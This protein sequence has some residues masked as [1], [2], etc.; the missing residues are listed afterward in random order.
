MLAFVI[1]KDCSMAVP[2]SRGTA[3]ICCDCPRW[4]GRSPCRP[5]P[6]DCARGTINLNSP[7]EI[8]GEYGI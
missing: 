5:Q 3:T 2:A 1:Q 6:N 8:L 7:V 4:E